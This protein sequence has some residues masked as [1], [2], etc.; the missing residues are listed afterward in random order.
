MWSDLIECL[1]LCLQLHKSKHSHSSGAASIDHYINTTVRSPYTLYS[2]KKTDFNIEKLGRE[3]VTK[4]PR[5]IGK[6]G[7]PL[8]LLK[9]Y[10][11]I[12]YI[13][14]PYALQNEQ[15]RFQQFLILQLEWGACELVNDVRE[16][17]CCMIQQFGH[18]PVREILLL[19][20]AHAIDIFGTI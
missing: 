7:W 3:V 2:D 18:L 10:S 15:K 8:N 19:Y 9:S 4:C 5:Y 12:C 16:K 11:T 17:G 1:S 20:G 6:R 14:S 13:S